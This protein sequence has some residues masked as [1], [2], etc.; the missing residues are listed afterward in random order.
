M[1]KTPTVGKIATDLLAKADDKHTVVDQMQ[2]NL[3]E[4]DKNIWLCVE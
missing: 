4:Y 1:E 2:E 3:T